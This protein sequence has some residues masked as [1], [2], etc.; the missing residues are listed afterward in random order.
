MMKALVGILASCLLVLGACTTGSVGDDVN[1]GD[2]SNEDTDE[3]LCTTSF[4]LTGTYTISDPKPTTVTGCWPIGSWSFSPT[5]TSNNCTPS[6]TPDGNYTFT[7]AR[8]TTSAEPDFDWLYS[9]PADPTAELHVSSGGGGLCEAT[10]LI[11]STDG[12]Q[13]FNF[14]PALPD[15]NLDGL[16]DGTIDGNGTFEIHTKDQRS[17]PDPV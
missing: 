11:Y 13:V 5:V 8:D 16:A 1:V 12:K 10:L 15:L 3:I 6:P 14:H 9:Y 2:D 17:V 7:V 4:S